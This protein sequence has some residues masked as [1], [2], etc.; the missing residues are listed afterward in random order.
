MGKFNSVIFYITALLIISSPLYAGEVIQTQYSESKHEKYR[1]REGKFLVDT[2]VLYVQARGNQGWPSVAFDGTNYLVVWQDSRCFPQHDIY[3]AR[4]SFQGVVLDS[5]GIHIATVTYDC[6][7]AY[8][9]GAPAVS[10]NGS[11]Y[12]VVWQDRQYS[13]EIDIY[14]ARI[15][16]SGVILD[17]NGIPISTATGHQRQHHM[18]ARGTMRY[19]CQLI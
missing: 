11:E 3:G 17:S 2:N 8:C 18:S 7:Q 16:T 9:D 13:S 10:Y 15:T 6:N 14:G 19:R 4:V 1:P 5:A 12:F